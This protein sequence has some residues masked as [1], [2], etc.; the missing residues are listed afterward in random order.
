M[1]NLQKLVATVLLVVACGL[2]DAQESSR[3]DGNWWRGEQRISKST[4]VVGFFD[5]ME[6]GRN[7][8]YWKFANNKLAA[9]SVALVNESYAEYVDKYF[10]NVSNVQLVDGLDVFYA[11]FRNR[12]ILV[13]NAV[14]IVTHQISGLPQ[15]RVDE[16]IENWRKNSTR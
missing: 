13:H 16:M 5:G 11:D 2:S 8:S 10:K 9:N 14:W 7:F 3:R 4:Y 1:I 6:L 12:S 15:E